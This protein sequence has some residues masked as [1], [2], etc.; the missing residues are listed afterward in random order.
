[1]CV[2]VCVCVCARAC[3]LEVGWGRG[4]NQQMVDVCLCVCVCASTHAYVCRHML[5]HVCHRVP[6]QCLLIHWCTVQFHCVKDLS[7]TSCDGN[8]NH[9]NNNS[10]D[11][12]KDDD[13]VDNDDDKCLRPLQLY[14]PVDRTSNKRYKH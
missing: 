14:L 9:N 13:D 11:N 7:I 6:P 1:M 3:I 12:N 4:G 8:Y 2:C 5:M 10:G